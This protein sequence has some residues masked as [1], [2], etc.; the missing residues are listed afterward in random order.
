MGAGFASAGIGGHISKW[1]VGA[2]ELYPTS[3]TTTDSAINGLAH[4]EDAMLSVGDEAWV[5]H[6]SPTSV[7]APKARAAT[8]MRSAYA[9]LSLS[10][11]SSAAADG[12]GDAMDV[13]GAG[14]AE[15]A[16][17]G[18]REMLLVGGSAPAIDCFTN[19]SSL[20]FSL[21]L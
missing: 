2:S 15:G 1:H 6:W 14:E 20:A 11:R 4:H 12:G 3:W 18:M 16:E 8:S 13:V 17:A 9:A 10:V 19:P 7:T 21:T 5:T